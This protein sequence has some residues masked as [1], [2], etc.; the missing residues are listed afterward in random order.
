M[1]KFYIRTTCRKLL[2]DTITPV[3]IYLRLR[4]IFPNSLLLESSD[5]HGTENSY[6][7]ICLKPVAG[8]VADNG[9]IK[10][11]YPDGTILNHLI[12]SPQDFLQ[13]F[14]SFF[15]SF[16]LTETD[17]EIPVNG[18]FGYMSYDA[19]Q[20]VEKIRLQAP[21]NTDCRIPHVRYDFYKYI[22]AVN[23][24]QNIL[25]I[26]ENQING[27]NSSEAGNIEDLLRN[28]NFAIYRF[29][30]T[31][32]EKSNITDEQYKQIVKKGKEHC[33]RGDVFQVVLSRQYSVDFKGDEFNV[34]RTLRSINP[35]PYLFYFDY[36]NYKIFGSS[37]EAHLKINR[38]K[39]YINPIAGTYRRTGNDEADKMMAE[40]LGYDQKENA[41]HIML[42]D[43]ARNDLSRHAGNV[44]VEN[45]REVQF[46]S[47]VIHLVSS[48]SGE[49]RE[50][51]TMAEMLAATFPA[52][53]LTGAPKHMAMQL[54]DRYENQKRGYYGGAIGFIDFRGVLN[55]AI[56]IR[57]F[58]SMGNRLF[59]QAGAGIVAGS[60]EEK[61]LQEVNNKLDAL[62]HAV[63]TAEEI[64]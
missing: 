22:I 19:V 45:L 58:L 56:M 64:K 55:H 25:Y 62:K 5:Y 27:D 35:S 48:V 26:I 60:D 40:R 15:E 8:F 28:R 52:G 21:E 37:P 36:G 44:T 32:H 47:H 29:R 18:I 1:K 10:E 11:I 30:T 12:T 34:Y 17:N 2:A 63:K 57:T 33:Y 7:F 31:G 53:T 49:L 23:H 51:T 13:R 4:D 54:I 41:E 3:S 20:Y 38:G 59:Y 42:V 39:A 24:H 46:Y 9:K 6:S 50:G 43:L 16:T 14:S 61:E